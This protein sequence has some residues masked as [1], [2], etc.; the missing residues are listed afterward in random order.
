VLQTG[1]PV[2]MPWLASVPAV[3]EAWY[4]GS[5]GGDAIAAVLFGTVNP[6]GRLPITFPQDETQLPRPAVRN[7]ESTQANPGEPLKGEMF[8]VDY[9]I[10]GPDVGYKW[11]ARTGRQALFPFGYGLSYT[12]FS[13]GPVTV[14]TKHGI[15]A[16]TFDV[17]NTGTR[18]GIDTPQVYVESPLFT[19]RLAGWRSVALRPGEKKRV[20]V[21]IDAR[22]LAHYDVKGHCWRI[23]KDRYNASVRPDAVGAGPETN[24][25]VAARYIRP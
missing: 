2:T 5:R 7:P 23:A 3:M 15:T 16:V 14:T 12:R 21:T 13:I 11:F 25:R 18:D 1:G 10:E 17:T 8:S 9:N 19:R 22:L 4:S 24:F 6:S 20:S